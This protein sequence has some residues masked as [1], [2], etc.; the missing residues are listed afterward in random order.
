MAVLKAKKERMESLWDLATSELVGNLDKGSFSEVVRT[1][2]R[3]SR[4]KVK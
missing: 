4:V 3:L 1:E 2:V